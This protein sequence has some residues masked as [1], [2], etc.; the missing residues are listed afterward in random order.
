MGKRLFF[1]SLI[2]LSVGMGINWFKNRPKAAPRPRKPMVAV[3]LEDLQIGGSGT[4]DV[5]TASG[6]TPIASGATPQVA[7]VTASNVASEA[8]TATNAG[9]ASAT[10]GIDPIVLAFNNLNRNPFAPSPFAAMMAKAGKTQE[11][12][13]GKVVEKKGKP[14]SVLSNAFT[15]TIETK[16]QL[17]AILDSRLYKL[18]DDFNGKSIKKLEKEMITLEDENGIYL[19]PKRGVMINLASDGKIISV[20][21]GYRKKP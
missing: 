5:A 6:D 3:N 12:Q 10:E 7:S 13:N 4:P 20:S 21:D 19:I 9:A 2:V 17:V 14:T 11:E 18:G 16:T 8:V 1:L 15:S